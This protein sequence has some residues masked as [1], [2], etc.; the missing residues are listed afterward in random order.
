MADFAM[1]KSIPR[2]YIVQGNIVQ[3]KNLNFER[4][5]K[6][7]LM[8]ECVC[9]Y[10]CM[11]MCM[12]K[13]MYVCTYVCII[14]IYIYIYIYIGNNWYSYSYGW[15][16]VSHNIVII[17]PNPSLP[18]LHSLKALN[19]AHGLAL[20]AHHHSVPVCVNIHCK[21]SNDCYYRYWFVQ[22]CLNYHHNIYVHMI[23]CVCMCMWDYDKVYVCMSVSIGYI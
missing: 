12:Y 15:W 2:L 8:C 17:S 1:K 22:P 5:L 7:S 19:G 9:M 18:P 3:G 20:A 4:I 13:C 23:R 10:M 6:C 16:R 21:G 14:Y 11:Y